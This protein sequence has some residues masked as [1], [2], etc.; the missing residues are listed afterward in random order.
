MAA[1][2]NKPIVRETINPSL[3]EGLKHSSHL[4]HHRGKE[5]GGGKV[6]CHQALTVLS[7]LNAF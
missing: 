6:T 2:N 5:W 3:V 1:T 4:I 7:P